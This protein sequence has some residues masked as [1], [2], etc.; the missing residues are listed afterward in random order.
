MYCT[1][2]DD[3]ILFHVNMKKCSTFFLLKWWR[4]LLKLS[5]AIVFLLILSDTIVFLLKLS[6]TIVF[7]LKLSGTIVFLLNYQALLSFFW[8]YQTLLSFFW[9]YQ[10]LFSFFWNYQTL[11]SCLGDKEKFS[12]LCF[13]VNIRLNK[14]TSLLL[15]NLKIVFEY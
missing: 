10:A 12:F 4:F 15:Q 6:D 13:Y 9:N 14:N 5:D 11:L 2:N 3:L 7:L 1:K 8:N